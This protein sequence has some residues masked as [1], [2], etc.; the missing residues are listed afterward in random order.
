MLTARSVQK[1][2]SSRTVLKDVDLELSPG[3]VTRLDASNGSGKSTLLRL[4]AGAADPDS[5]TI[6]R[7]LGSVGYVPDRWVPPPGFTAL[8]FLRL[9]SASEGRRHPRTQ[10]VLER[11]DVKPD[12]RTRLTAL[13]KGNA[14]KVLCTHAFGRPRGTLI[15]DEPTNGLDLA[16]VSVLEELIDE[17]SQEGT[18]VLVVDHNS[19]QLRPHRVVTL[20]D[21][22][23]F[24]VALDGSARASVVID[25]D[26]D[27]GSRPFPFNVTGGGV[28][29]WT[30][31][32]G[33]ADVAEILRLA[34][35]E[36]WVIRSVQNPAGAR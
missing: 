19:M 25:K 32:C 24:K 6:E 22:S 8:S 10:T 29:D 1:S 2:Y 31:T 4:L 17:A 30:I 27:V 26:A 3:T 12:T 35:Q 11:L 20:R 21:G 18:A 36:R 34:L 5:G 23:L 16:A 7:G 13:S 33:E 14:Q 15:L 9:M 28:A